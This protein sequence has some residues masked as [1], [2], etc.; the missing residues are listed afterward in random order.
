MLRN[1]IRI[2]PARKEKGKTQTPVLYS[3]V[4]ILLWN[5]G[6]HRNIISY[7]E[8]AFILLLKCKDLFAMVNKY[9]QRKKRN[10]KSI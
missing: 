1:P 3:L 2:S 7:M 9:K 8:N 5:I 4:K 6:Q 10:F